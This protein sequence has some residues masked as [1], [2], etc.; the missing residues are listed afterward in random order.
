MW[1][2]IK[3]LFK[4]TKT[5]WYRAHDVTT[6]EYFLSGLV[7]IPIK[8]DPSYAVLMINQDL[9]EKFESQVNKGALSPSDWQDIQIVDLHLL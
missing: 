7:T 3:E 5:Y 1:S 6:N 4:P 9:N 2:L 8:E